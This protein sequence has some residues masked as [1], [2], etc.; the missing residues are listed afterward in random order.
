MNA[1]TSKAQTA[2]APTSPAVVAIGAVRFGNRLPLSIIAG[3]CAM[4]SREHAL[5]MAGALK[6][7]ATRLGVGL[8]YKSSFDK[9][10]RTSAA[11]GRG[12]GLDKAL[13]VFA[14]VKERLGLPVLTD[15]HEKEQCAPV[16]EVVDV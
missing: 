9:A 2:R 6:E 4:E 1:Q 15:V 7:I 11:S 16:G 14:E 5:E 13:S 12:I 3:P 10:N 8:V